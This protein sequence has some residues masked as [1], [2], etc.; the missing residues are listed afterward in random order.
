MV[1]S[2]IF[3]STAA[4]HRLLFAAV[5]GDIGFLQLRPG[6]DLASL[7]PV[8]DQSK[9]P[10]EI[11]TM[12]KQSLGLMLSAALMLGATLPGTLLA[13]AAEPAVAGM[14]G[15]QLTGKV[16]VVN[17]DTRLM[18]LK[19]AEGAYHVLHVPP[20]VTRLDELKIGDEVTI[21]EFSTA[22]IELIPAD[23]A[24]PVASERSTDVDRQPGKKPSGSITDTLTVYGKVV[25]MDKADGTVTIEGPNQTRTLDVDDPSLLEGVSVGDGVIARFQN[26]IIGEVK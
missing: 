13:Q 12:Q 21:T 1:I 4:L 15:A 7:S 9:T 26:V 19:D 20:E 3:G 17:Q 24:G 10:E 18:T 23:E 25:A 22:L 14:M 8:R 6:A 2:R 5:G 16:M 11:S